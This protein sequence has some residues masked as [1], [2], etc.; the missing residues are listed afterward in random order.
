M[1]CPL[2]VS[3]RMLSRGKLSEVLSQLVVVLVDRARQANTLW[4]T[5]QL[6]ERGGR[7]ELDQLDFIAVELLWWKAGPTVDISPAGLEL[8]AWK[9]M[10]G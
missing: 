4:S 6:V 9:A 3:E 8:P 7:R 1:R 10:S 5:A 2:P